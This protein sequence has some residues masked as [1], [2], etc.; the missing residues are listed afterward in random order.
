M[1][2]FTKDVANKQLHVVR[3][4]NAP[5]EKIWKAWT[6]S[7][8]LDQWW[9]PKPWRTETKTMNFKPGGQWIYAMIGPDGTK[10]WSTV[11]FKEI[12]APN[13]YESTCIFSDENGNAIDGF[14]TLYWEVKMSGDNGITTVNV[15][16]TFDDAAGLEQIIAMGFEG[17]FTIGLSQLD[18]L[19]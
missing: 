4:F 2:K 3:T 7:I 18:E 13:G 17:G 16:L 10:S 14:H 6:D 12:D 8:I 9:G 5:Q 1:I 11:L 15:T 19:L